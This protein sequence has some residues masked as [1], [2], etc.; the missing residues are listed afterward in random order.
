MMNLVMLVGRLSKEV[1]EIENGCLITLSIKRTISNENGEFEEDLAQVRA[2]G[3][4]A[5]NV[6]KHCEIGTSI[7]IKG[8]LELKIVDNKCEVSVIA[9][10]I[11]FLSSNKKED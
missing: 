6:K 1:E 10:K 3:N 4:L 7:G 8:R 9:D 11:T 2:F 5:D